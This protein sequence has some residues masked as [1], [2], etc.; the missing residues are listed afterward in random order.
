M[1]EWVIYVMLAAVG[2]AG[3]ILVLKSRN[4]DEMAEY[5]SEQA[6]IELN[7][8]QIDA[9][10]EV[11]LAKVAAEHEEEMTKIA[12]GVYDGIKI[13]SETEDDNSETAYTWTVTRVEDE[14]GSD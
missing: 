2:V 3:L 7:I 6:F 14:H 5:P 9:N 10:K 11:A 1:P 4:D 8:R 13:N 12:R